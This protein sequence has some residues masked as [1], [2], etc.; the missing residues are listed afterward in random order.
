MRVAALVLLALIAAA[1]VLDILVVGLAYVLTR[2][3]GLG[4]RVDGT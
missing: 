4:K 1:V 3:G 2:P